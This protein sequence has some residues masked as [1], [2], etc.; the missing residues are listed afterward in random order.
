M[1]AQ[2]DFMY[3]LPSLQ[4]SVLFLPSLPIENDDRLLYEEDSLISLY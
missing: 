1:G 2:L 3:P 4:I